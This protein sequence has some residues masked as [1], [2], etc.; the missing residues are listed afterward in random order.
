MLR[1]WGGAL[2]NL[3]EGALS[4]YIGGGRGEGYN[5]AVKKPVK[6]FIC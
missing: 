1:T 3:I 6:E 2:Q 4:Q 5:A